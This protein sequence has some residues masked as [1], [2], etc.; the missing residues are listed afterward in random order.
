MMTSVHRSA[1]PFWTPKR[2]AS[3]ANAIATVCCYVAVYV[4][5]DW[6]SFIQPLP[7]SGFTPWNYPHRARYQAGAVW[8]GPSQG[9]IVPSRRM[10]GCAEIGEDA[11][12]C[13]ATETRMVNGRETGVQTT[14]C[15][16]PSQP[17]TGMS[18]N[19]SFF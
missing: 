10:W 19:Y 13:D 16:N 15:S 14:C 11:F 7:G 4:A 1:W 9:S 6:I 2:R 5:L 12:C 18:C 8:P 3:A 17:G